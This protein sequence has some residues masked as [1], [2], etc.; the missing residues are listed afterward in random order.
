MCFWFTFDIQVGFDVYND[1]FRLGFGFLLSF[2]IS[3]TAAH[4]RAFLAVAVVLT[5]RAAT[6]AASTS[7]PPPRCL[8][9]DTASKSLAGART[10]PPSFRTGL[11][12]TAGPRLGACKASFTFCAAITRAAS[13]RTPFGAYRSCKQQKT[14]TCPASCPPPPPHYIFRSSFSYDSL[15][16][17]PN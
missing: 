5:L 12:P 4:S 1:F 7:H 9:E 14:R 17:T 11:L 2:R 8:S 10:M 13:R 3:T 15:R 6:P 16:G